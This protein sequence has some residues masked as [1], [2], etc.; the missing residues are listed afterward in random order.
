MEFKV[1]RVYAGYKKYFY[2]LKKK[3][4]FYCFYDGFGGMEGEVVKKLTGDYHKARFSLE[5]EREAKEDFKI[6]KKHI[7]KLNQN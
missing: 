2:K 7:E 5:G 6:H 4:G 3:K 1:D